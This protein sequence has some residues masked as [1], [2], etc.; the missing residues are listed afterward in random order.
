MRCLSSAI[1]RVHFPFRKSRRVGARR[2]R[3][4]SRH[5]PRRR[6]KHVPDVEREARCRTARGVYQLELQR[7]GE[8]DARRAAPPMTVCILDRQE[9]RGWVYSRSTSS[10]GPKSMIRAVRLV[11]PAFT[12]CAWPERASPAMTVGRTDVR[13][14]ADLGVGMEGG[15]RCLAAVDQPIAFARR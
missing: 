10:I 12:I 14:T 8:R 4:G 5:A 6:G 7:A 2:A 9:A 11:S 13:P 1:S 3:V 15:K